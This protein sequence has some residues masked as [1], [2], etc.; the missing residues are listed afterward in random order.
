MKLRDKVEEPTAADAWLT[1]IRVLGV[2]YGPLDQLKVAME[3]LV[4]RLKPQSG[5][6]GAGRALIWTL[7]K[8]E[9]LHTLSKIERLKTFIGLALQE[10]LLWVRLVL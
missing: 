9:C 2:E 6:K 5:I 10:E 3:K 1:G 4:K 7:D 8:Q